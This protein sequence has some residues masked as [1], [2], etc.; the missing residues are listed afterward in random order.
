MRKTSK[1]GILAIAILLI[2]GC[3]AISSGEITGKDYTAA[4]DV[5]VSYCAMYKTDS[6]GVSTCQMYATR[7]DHYPARW[8][9]NLKQEEKTG[10]V[11]V[12]ENVWNEYEVG[13][14][15]NTEAR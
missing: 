11:D 15:Y 1:L 5:P 3:S 14:F 2:S 9:F 12:P 6:Q 4:Y 8:T 10:W 7:Y 13:D